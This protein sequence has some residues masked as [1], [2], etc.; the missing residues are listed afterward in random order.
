MT[1]VLPHT[2]REAPREIRFALTAVVCAAVVAG[3]LGL[4]GHS[5]GPLRAEGVAARAPVVSRTPSFPKLGWEEAGLLHGSHVAAPRGSRDQVDG[6]GSGLRP[7]TPVA[8][9]LDTLRA[10]LA[11]HDAR[12]LALAEG[13]LAR[14]LPSR[15]TPLA[16]RP[17]TVNCPAQG[18]PVWG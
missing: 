17:R 7:P 6:G 15:L 3:F 18:P 13:L 12:M 10:L 16:D 9:R 5:P 4:V 8:P 1:P 2:G 11:R 14:A